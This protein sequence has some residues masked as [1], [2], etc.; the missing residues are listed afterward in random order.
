MIDRDIS[1]QDAYVLKEI[2]KGDKIPII[3]DTMFQAM[4]NNE[5]RKKYAAYLVSLVLQVKYQEV[6]NNLIFMKER[7]DKEKELEKGK[8][9]DFVCKI[10]EEIVGIEMNN[11]SKV[12]PMLE[13][14]ISYAAD[15]YKSN[16]NKGRVYHYN[17]VIQI[18]INNFS[19]K[20]NNEVIERYMIRNE[21]GEIFTDKLEF[22]HIYLPN[23]KKKRYNKL[24][25]LEKLLLVFN[26]D[27][28][29]SKTLAKGDG[30]ME[31]FIKDAVEAS[32]EDEIIGLYDKELHLEKLRLSELE[33]E[34]EEAREEGLKEGKEEGIKQG[35]EEGIKE[36][37]KES[38]IN[39]AKNMLIKGLS[40][41]LIVELTGISSED[42]SSISLD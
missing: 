10:N 29:K 33:L 36:G 14:N 28:N 18:N 4:I 3:S 13:R 1:K 38:T 23:I 12:K 8:T 9:V 34:R 39:I 2:K 11:N 16:L 19:F 40:T 20:N 31:E 32:D 15:L 35:I 21:K 37:I 27:T 17:K 30:I 24:N 25:K 7:L 5:K 41:D 6:Y 26:E 42:L 22:I